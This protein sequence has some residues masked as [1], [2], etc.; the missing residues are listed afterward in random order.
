MSGILSLDLKLLNLSG[1]LTAMEIEF[2]VF[3][4]EI[5]KTLT[6]FSVGSIL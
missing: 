2:Q 1:D 4:P 6:N 5:K 3:G